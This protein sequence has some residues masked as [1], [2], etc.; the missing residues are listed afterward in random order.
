[1]RLCGSAAGA[2]DFG[3]MSPDIAAAE[4][5]SVISAFAPGSLKS[6]GG[7][8]I[9]PGRGLTSSGLRSGS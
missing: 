7:G 5:V 6:G 3:A 9:P 2:V 8:G 4:S 1:V